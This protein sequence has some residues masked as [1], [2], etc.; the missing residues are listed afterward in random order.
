MVEDEFITR[1]LSSL[2]EG[3]SYVG[4]GFN[5]PLYVTP[6]PSWVQEI[7][8]DLGMNTTRLLKQLTP[9]IE[10]LEN[11][12]CIRAYS[13]P[14]VSDRRNVLAVISKKIVIAPNSSY[15]YVDQVY[16]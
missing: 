5:S 9:Q 16:Y 14:L 10:R 6:A 15:N 8:V 3:H 1:P 2:F 7:A 4:A 11:A 12:D 13:Q